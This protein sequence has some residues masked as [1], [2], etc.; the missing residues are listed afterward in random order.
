MSFDQGTGSLG[1]VIA[2]RGSRATAVFPFGS[3]S[4]AVRSRATVG[5]FVGILSGASLLVSAVTDVTLKND[6]GNGVSQPST[7]A[8]LDIIGEIR[9]YKEPGARFVRGVGDYPAIG[10]SVQLLGSEELRIIFDKS[11]SAVI[12]IGRLQLDQELKAYIDVNEMLSKHFAV[13]GTTG[14]GK[15]S[16]VA[17][18]LQKVVEARPD[19]H[20]LI[21]DVHNEYRSCF[22]DRALALSPR[23]M[24]LP[25]WMFNFEELI[26]IF[27][28]GR[29]D[30]VEEIDVLADLIPI[31]KANYNNGPAVAS[32]TLAVKRPDAVG[33][34]Y[35]VDTPVP[36]R[37]ADLM[38]LID[39]QMGKLENRALISH[40]KRLIA[41]IE[42]VSAD[43]RYAFIF[44]RANVGGDTMADRIGHMFFKSHTGVPVT[45]FQLAGFPS[46]VVDSLVSVIARLAFD[47]G[48]WSDGGKPLLLVCEEAHRYISADRTLGF[49][50]TR[51]AVSRIAK[52]GRKY[53]VFLG[54]V[55]QRP[56]EL[57][58]TILSQCSTLFAMRM[59]NDRD[60]AL[61][62]AAVPDTAA[63][64]LSFLPSLGT[65]EVFAFGE[66]VALPTRI[67]LSRLAPH[68]LPKS[69]AVG[70]KALD[71]AQGVAAIVNRW[72][73]GREGDRASEPAPTP[74]ELTLAF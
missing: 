10:D 4:N 33:P 54:L 74:G 20:V 46:E 51:R 57:D 63:D 12:E 61:L 38:A 60:Q 22:G 53:G 52:E 15:S 70:G 3:A 2:V 59:T 32:R 64:L 48:Q 35:S 47:L 73:G 6:G 56:A 37:I 62:H 1:S 58:A 36:Y 66:G 23:N 9:N 28:S 50:P 21:L 55:T 68:E 29:K 69:E 67:R 44:E 49:G 34:R 14:V 40:Y 65:G 39:A 72:R 18:L 7:L 45:I 27:F 31:A 17:L 16:A 71:D 30:F 8:T 5:K 19:L 26:D 43:P 25:F 42:S 11:N 41:R 13:L 24:R